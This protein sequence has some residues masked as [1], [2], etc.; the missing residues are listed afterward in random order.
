[1]VQAILEMFT[2]EQKAE[3]ILAN[4]MI[5]AIFILLFGLF[6]IAVL[7][8]ITLFGKLK[9][10]RNYVKDTNRLD[11]EPLQG[12]QEQFNNKQGE[13]VKAE[14]FVQ[15][16]FSGWRIFQ[17][18]VV[19]LI[20]MIQMTVSVF[21]LLG[22]LGTF[23][24]LT[25][26]L[27][28]I[29]INDSDLVEG[30]AGVLAGIDVAFYTSIAGM[31]FSLIMTLLIKIMNTEF[32][33][34]DIMLMTESSLEGTEQNNMG[35]L[36][37]VSEAINQSILS[38]QKT[39]QQ[40]LQGIEASFTGFKEYTAGLQQSAKDLAAFNDGLSDN[41]EEFQGLFQH[42]K[43]VTDGFSEGTTNLN[44]NFDSLFSYFKK[45]DNK[46]E[47]MVKV[48]ENTFEKMKEVSDT[49]MKTLQ[50]FE[51]S[52]GEIK[53][54]TSTLLGEQETM[55][56]S[57]ERIQ[58]KSGELVNVMDHQNKAFQRIFGEDLST[59][60]SGVMTYLG[61]LSREF[62]KMGSSIV[63]LPDA[64]EVINQTQAEYKHLL[65]DRFTELKEFNRTFSQHLKNHSSESMTY[66]KH[67][68][69]T[70]NTFEQIGM[71]NNQLIQDINATV[72]QMN[73]GFRQREN[74]MEASVGILKDT[75]S[76]YVGNLEG[77]LGN[78]LDSLLQS[79]GRYVEQTNDSIRTEFKEVQRITEA[80]H[81]SN[82][83]FIQQTLQEIS[84]E[85]QS[86][87]QRRTIPPQ[88]Q[89]GNWS[90]GI[91]MNQNDF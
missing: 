58:E 3:A 77:S 2:S 25:S 65:S 48:F 23:I 28:S 64:L 31:G 75:L 57:F 55:H 13:G 56:T 27:G 62:D 40:S 72:S 29:N 7:L 32:I 91:G 36:I 69:D 54:F 35:R 68:Q 22:V 34:T 76:N 53:Q 8:H 87:N 63:K 51:M 14:T 74:Q 9:K 83:R 78:K 67:M 45:M 59:K 89:S 86:I 20:K 33:L 37:G 24:G 1:M 38:L 21:I 11:I 73:N 15:E 43:D 18:P 4:S 6:I 16:K 61:E 10:V 30:V 66:E 85:L 26:S 70:A 17:V 71:K 90:N 50:Q 80:T 81:Q 60:L 5:E 46:N 44:K 41:L 52:V 12:F 47:R 88:Q 19:S 82:G 39:N 49:Q 84:R 79:F 42:M